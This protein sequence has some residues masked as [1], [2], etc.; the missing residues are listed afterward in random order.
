MQQQRYPK[1]PEAGLYINRNPEFYGFEARPSDPRS[2][3]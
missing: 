2:L 3:P 1:G